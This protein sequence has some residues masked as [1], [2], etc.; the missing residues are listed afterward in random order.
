MGLNQKQLEGAAEFRSKG[1]L[2]RIESG[3]RLPSL[4]AL[5]QLAHCL[6]V[7]PRDLLLFPDTDTVAAAMERTRQGGEPAAARVV[8][9]FDR[10]ARELADVRPLRAAESKRPPKKKP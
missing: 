8:D 9:L 1:Y 4:H 10:L 7:E 6:R 3:Q 5:E 2:S